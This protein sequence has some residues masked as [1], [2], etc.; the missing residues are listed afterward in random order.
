MCQT[1]GLIMPDEFFQLRKKEICL[2]LRNDLVLRLQAHGAKAHHI[3]VLNDLMFQC[4]LDTLDPDYPGFD[5]VDL[6]QAF[7]AYCRAVDMTSL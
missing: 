2:A 6:D 3:V 1:K 5:S 4:A 7:R